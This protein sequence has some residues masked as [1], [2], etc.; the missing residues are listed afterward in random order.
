M[1]NDG[2]QLVDN[3][4]IRIEVESNYIEEQSEPESERFVFAYTVEDNQQ[5]SR[6]QLPDYSVVIGLLLTL[7]TNNRK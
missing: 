1:S 7:I 4:E 2:M 6:Y 3:N 5:Q